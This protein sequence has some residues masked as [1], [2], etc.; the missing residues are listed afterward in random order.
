MAHVKFSFLRFLILSKS[1]TNIPFV[2]TVISTAVP[3]FLKIIG[4]LLMFM[5]SCTALTGCLGFTML[6]FMTEYITV[7]ELCIDNPRIFSNISYPNGVLA[8]FQPQPAITRIPKLSPIW[9]TILEQKFCLWVVVLVAYDLS[10]LLI[11]DLYSGMCLPK[12]TCRFLFCTVL[13]L[14]ILEEPRFPSSQW[15]RTSSTISSFGS[16]SMYLGVR[17]QSWLISRWQHL[18][19]FCQS[20]FLAPYF[21]LHDV[22][23]HESLHT[24]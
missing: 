18:V 24:S 1:L 8:Q 2:S 21:L 13:T 11:C 10:Q 6:T 12:P 23:S 17:S 5:V 16:W 7:E 19:M 4:T 14:L 22:G 20:V 3:R 9:F 15:A